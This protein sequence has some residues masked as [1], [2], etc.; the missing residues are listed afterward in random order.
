MTQKLTE[1]LPVKACT[2]RFDIVVSITNI[3]P[4][5]AT[6]SIAEAQQL[7]LNRDRLGPNDLSHCHVALS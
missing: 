5:S 7:T 2:S 1:K 4:S 6:P 3:R